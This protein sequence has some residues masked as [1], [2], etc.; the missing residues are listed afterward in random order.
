VWPNERWLGYENYD[1]VHELMQSLQEWAYYKSLFFSLSWHEAK[2]S[3]QMPAPQT[4]ASQQEDGESNKFAYYELSILRYSVIAPQNKLWKLVLLSF[5]VDSLGLPMTFTK[6]RVLLS[7]F[8]SI[9]VLFIF[10]ILLHWLVLQYS[11]E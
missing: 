9:Y 1:P 2:E 10:L 7:S 6:T 3:R 8:F 4:W 11:V 5:S